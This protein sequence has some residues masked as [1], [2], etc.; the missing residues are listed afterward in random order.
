M[1]ASE[2]L[3]KLKKPIERAAGPV[4]RVS[5]E[6]PL[7]LWKKAKLAAFEAGEPLRDLI[8]AGLRAELDRRGKRK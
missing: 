6:I 8:L 2:P 5:L 4:R 3:A 7:D 1:A